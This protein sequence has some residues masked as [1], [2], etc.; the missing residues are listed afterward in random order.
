MRILAKLQ[1]PSRKLVLALFDVL[2]FV[3][4]DTLFYLFCREVDYSIPVNETEFF[5]INSALLL[6]GVML[7]RLGLNV[8]RTVWRY[9]STK[10]YFCMVLADFFGGIG[11]LLVAYGLNTYRGMWHFVLVAALTA[12]ASLMARFSYRLLYKHAQRSRRE[13]RNRHNTAI[14]GAGT[15]GTFLAHDLIGNPNSNYKPLFFVD[16]DKGKIGNTVAGLLVINNK[17]VSQYLSAYEITDVIIA[18][19]GIDSEQ[20]TELYHFYRDKGC[21]VKIYDSV[22]HEIGT[23]SNRVIR[24]FQIEDLL[25]RKPLTI[26]DQKVLDY[27]AGKTVLVTGGGGSIGSEICRQIARCKPRKLVIFDIYENNA[28]DIQ[29]ELLRTY[30]ENINLEVEI[31]SVRDLRRL[32]N[33][34]QA[35]RPDVVFHA[36]AHKHVPLMEHSGYEAIKNNVMGTKNTADMAEKFGVQKFILIS[37]DKAVNPT[38]IMGASKRMC[39]MVIQCRTDSKTSF[40][41]V[42]FGN[43]LGSNGSVIPLF[44]RQIAS[45]GPLTVTDKRIIRYFMTIQEASQLVIQAG[46]MAHRGELFVLDMGKPV[47]IYDLAVN[48]IKLSG[49]EPG[50]DIEI[51]EVGL[52]PGEKLYEELLMQS[53][54]Q[55]K[56]ENNLIFIERDTPPTRAEVDE[57]LRLLAVAEEEDVSVL[58]EA[59][60]KAVPTYKDSHIVNKNASQSKEMQLVNC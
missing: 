26:N 17:E 32:E 14:V 49:L 50:K 43:V 46:A 25:F 53:D 60:A 35:H 36:A 48:M 28:Y 4:V 18:I 37:T 39:E 20:A 3:L 57:K 47:K 29:Q 42:R 9:T 5:L 31:G 34:F 10:A 1:G 19:A 2:C 44:K 23:D 7:F 38:N 55:E 12:L 59:L 21:N 13:N 45:G 52:R 24:D 51:Q 56:T 15:L 8:Y 40:A 11:A 30:G 6:V 22:V 27:Y 58:K 33:V 16:K 54:T 41:A